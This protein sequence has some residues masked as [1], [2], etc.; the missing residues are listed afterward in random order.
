MYI[1]EITYKSDDKEKFA[2][3]WV[4]LLLHLQK[5]KQQNNEGQTIIIKIT[6]REREQKKLRTKRCKNTNKL[7]NICHLVI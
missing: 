3:L 2:R 5:K 1:C 4:L 7:I 6:V